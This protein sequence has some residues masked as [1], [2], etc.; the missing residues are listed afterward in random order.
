M[1]YRIGLR[2]NFKTEKTVGNDGIERRVRSAVTQGGLFPD[3]SRLIKA[4]RDICKYFASPQKLNSFKKLQDANHLPSGIPLLDGKTRVASCHKLLQSS[5]LHHWSLKYYY[6]S[7]SL[8]LPKMNSI[9]S[10]LP[11]AMKI[12]L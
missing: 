3:G 11:L 2:D 7:L 10:G 1:L 6:Q 12:G 4:L 5:I 9:I 8:I